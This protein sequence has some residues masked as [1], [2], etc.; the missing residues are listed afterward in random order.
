LGQW[1][2]I[3]VDLGREKGVCPSGKISGLK[4]IEKH[5][6]RRGDLG[7]TVPVEK[8]GDTGVGVLGNQR[9]T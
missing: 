7:Q 6:K 8:K 5:H 4:P 1:R 2:K 9:T 3:Q